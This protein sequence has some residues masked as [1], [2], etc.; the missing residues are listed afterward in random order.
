MLFALPGAAELRP[1]QDRREPGALP[2]A[3]LL[4]DG[5]RPFDI[6][7]LAAVPGSHSSGADTAAELKQRSQGFRFSPRAQLDLRSWH[8]PK[9]KLVLGSLLLSSIPSCFLRAT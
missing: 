8:I 2:A 1:A 3:A 6:P 4:H 9:D 5:L 7:R